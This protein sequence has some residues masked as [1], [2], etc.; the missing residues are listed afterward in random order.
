MDTAELGVGLR[1]GSFQ[2]VRRFSEARRPVPLVL[3]AGWLRQPLGDPTRVGCD[4]Q[5]R[6][7]ARSSS[8]LHARWHR[9]A[10][11]GTLPSQLVEDDLA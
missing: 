6:F 9:H 2:R 7:D 8:L 3:G 1:L 11:V 4:L 10:T 5:E